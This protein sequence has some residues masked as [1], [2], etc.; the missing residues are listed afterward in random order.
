MCEGWVGVGGGGGGGG[1]GARLLFPNARWREIDSLLSG[2][3]LLHLAFA[4]TIGRL[5]PP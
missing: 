4:P 1:G 3:A 2:R 5:L